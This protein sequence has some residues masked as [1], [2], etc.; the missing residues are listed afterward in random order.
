MRG[1]IGDRTP[2]LSGKL[3]GGN[4][5]THLSVCEWEEVGDG[6][7]HLKR[8]GIFNHVRIRRKDS[9][10]RDVT[11]CHVVRYRERVVHCS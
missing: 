10:T 3:R 4:V 8:V 1:G 11:P 5:I 2:H 6:I 9:L 7:T